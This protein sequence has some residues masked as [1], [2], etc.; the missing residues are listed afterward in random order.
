RNTWSGIF[1]LLTLS[2]PSTART[3]IDTEYEILF[4]MP[5]ESRCQNECSTTDYRRSNWRL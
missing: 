4:A 5:V 1:V 3:R 2:L